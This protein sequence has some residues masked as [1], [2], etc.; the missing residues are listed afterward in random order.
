M[1]LSS[2]ALESLATFFYTNQLVQTPMMG[3]LR[4]FIGNPS[5]FWSPWF[6]FHPFM[7]S[8]VRE[9]F[10]ILLFTKTSMQ[11]NL[12]S[13]LLPVCLVY[14]NGITEYC[15]YLCEGCSEEGVTE[16]RHVFQEIAKKVDRSL[17]ASAKEEFNMCLTNWIRRIT[18]FAIQ[19]NEIS[20]VCSTRT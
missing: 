3:R 19:R 6:L 15:N 20:R 1:R 18:R 11:W 10:D 5:L 13:A 12:A 9:L 8:L 7:S 14:E 16:I 17:D 4:Q 2:S